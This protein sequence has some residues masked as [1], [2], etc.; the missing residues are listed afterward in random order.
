MFKSIVL[1]SIALYVCRAEQKVRYDNYKVIRIQV[2][3]L[4]QLNLMKDIQNTK[5]SYN[6]WKFPNGVGTFADLVVPP[7]KYDE[8]DSLINNFGLKVET[9]IENLQNVIDNEKAKGLVDE[10]DWEA[11]YSLTSIYNFINKVA[12]EHPNHVGID[13]FS[14]S[15]ENRPILGVKIA[16]KP[17]NDVIFIESNIHAR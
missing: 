10:L 16:Y 17:E 12:K 15:Y 1:L 4:E 3:D 7:H 14:R 11:Y 8:I 13:E 9:L 2:N 6:F 5:N